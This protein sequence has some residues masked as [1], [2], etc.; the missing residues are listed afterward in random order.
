MDIVKDGDVDERLKMGNSQTTYTRICKKCGKYFISETR[1]RKICNACL[2]KS[3]VI[4]IAK[5]KETKEC[6]KLLNSQVG[7]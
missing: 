7:K 5:M 6:Q 1:Y 3:K 2:E 4:R